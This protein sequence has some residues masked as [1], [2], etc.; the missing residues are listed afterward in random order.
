MRN[1]WSKHATL[2]M[3]GFCDGVTSNTAPLMSMAIV[4]IY[5]I[6][7][8]ENLNGNPACLMLNCSFGGLR[9]ITP[10]LCIALDSR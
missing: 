4:C 9:R 10:H 1:Q 3:S 5:A 6:V 8:M 2:A 7:P